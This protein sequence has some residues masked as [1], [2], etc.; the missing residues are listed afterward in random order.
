MPTE[1]NS[2]QQARYYDL[3]RLRI[4]ATLACANDAVLPF[5]IFHQT[6]IVMI[7]FVIYQ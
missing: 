2:N 3:G 5:Y 6:V 1:L 4:L 7:N